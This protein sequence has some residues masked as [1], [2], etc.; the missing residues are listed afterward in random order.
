MSSFRRQSQS[1]ALF[2]QGQFFSRYGF[3][4]KLTSLYHLGCVINLLGE[5]GG[6]GK[7][8]E[9]RTRHIYSKCIQIPENLPKT[10][11]LLAKALVTSAR[12]H[13]EGQNHTQKLIILASKGMGFYSQLYGVVYRRSFLLLAASLEGDH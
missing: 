13:G 3:S 6:T 12:F 10:H 7:I 8:P 4:D 1:P 9:Q 5:E 11:L 2:G